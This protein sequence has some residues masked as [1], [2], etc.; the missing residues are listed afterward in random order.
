MT[1]VRREM[2][3]S[4]LP[5]IDGPRTNMSFL[6]RLFGGAKRRGSAPRSRATALDSAPESKGLKPVLTSNS[7]ADPKKPDIG[8]AVREAVETGDPSHIKQILK[9]GTVADTRELGK[10]LLNATYNGNQALV[11]IL[12]AARVDTEARP[13]AATARRPRIGDTVGCQ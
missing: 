4:L 13:I 2:I 7:V 12:L 1:G 3:E 5:R 10:F 11:Q 9:S 6:K 8:S